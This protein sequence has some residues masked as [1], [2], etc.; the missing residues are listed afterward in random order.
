MLF[1]FIEKIWLLSSEDTYKD[2]VNKIQL[3]MYD[4]LISI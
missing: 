2:F 1:K 3:A 4:S